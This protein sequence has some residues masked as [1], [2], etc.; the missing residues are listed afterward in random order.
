MFRA[1]IPRKR[2]PNLLIMRTSSS[3]KEKK[4]KRKKKTKQ[5]HTHKKT[6]EVAGPPGHYTADSG[7]D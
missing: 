7:V 2:K 1:R 4:K 3:R 5:K 6:K